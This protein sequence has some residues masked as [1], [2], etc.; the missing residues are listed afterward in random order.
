MAD[1]LIGLGSNIGD[2]AGQFDEAV[3]HI[4]H[5]P[6]VSLQGSSHYHE[7]SPIGGPSG[8]D[9]FLNAVIRVVTSLSPEQLL[10][11]LNQVERQLGRER[12]ERWGPRTIDIDLLLYD[13]QVLETADL[14]IP[15]RRMATRRFVLEPACEVGPEM[16]H[17][18]TG[19]T[20]QKLLSRLDESPRYVAVCCADGR[21]STQLV[22]TAAAQ[23]N[24][25]A[26]RMGGNNEPPPVLQGSSPQA[27]LRC[28]PRLTC[29]TPRAANK[30]A[31]T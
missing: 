27:A 1:C 31:Q 7:T 8:Q 14:Q 13:S 10:V 23:M 24:A 2:R 9:P 15:H 21:R 26:L 30:H 28:A 12:I 17:G 29:R 16:I 6:D 22:M 4:C 3:R 19:W 18:P 5:A 20:L 11:R 25:T